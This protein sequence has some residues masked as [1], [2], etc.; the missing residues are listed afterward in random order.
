MADV[1]VIPHP[2]FGIDR[3]ADGT[4]HAER[5]HVVFRGKFIAEA[6]QSADGGGRGVEGIH[7]ELLDN[8]PETSSVGECRHAFEHQRRAAVAERTVN[9]IAVAGDP[10]NV[11]GAEIDVA[12]VDVENVFV[13]ERAPQQIAGGAVDDAL[14]FTS[15]TGG[16]EDEEIIF[17]LHLFRRAFSGGFRHQIVIPHVPTGDDVARLVVAFHDDDLLDAR[18]VRERGV[19]ELLERE[20]F[21]GAERDVRGDEQFAFGIVDATRK[22]IRAESTK[23]DRVN[24]PD[25]RAREH[26]DGSLGNHRHVNRDAVALGDAERLEDVGELADIIVQLGVRDVLHIFLGLALPDDGGLAADGF[27]MA[28]KAVHRDVEFAVLEPSVLDNALV[29]V[30]FKLACVRRLLEPSERGGLFHPEFFRII[31][32]ARIHGVVLRGIDQRVLYNFGRRRK[33]AAGLLE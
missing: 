33:R 27:E 4:E 15:R 22:G 7:F 31:D 14:G 29:G 23:H 13:R 18:R 25:A 20:G 8:L 26:R 30:P 1:F 6:N 28:I 24:R 17:G 11:G 2:R 32:G 19:S 3:F 12:F 5:R 16:V 9:H 10:A 21:S